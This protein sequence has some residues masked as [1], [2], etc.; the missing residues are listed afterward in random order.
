MVYNE[1][2]MRTSD[3]PAS[4]D[5]N[6]AHHSKTARPIQLN[7]MVP[8]PGFDMASEDHDLLRRQTLVANAADTSFE[9]IFFPFTSSI[10]TALC[11]NLL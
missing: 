7:E 10:I 5:A 6:T 9:N 11:F 2:T 4:I 3:D 1:P 8:R